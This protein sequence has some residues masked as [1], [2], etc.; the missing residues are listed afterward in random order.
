MGGKAMLKTVE[1]E[2]LTIARADANTLSVTDGKG[3]V[4]RITIPDV[5]QSNGIIHVVDKVLIPD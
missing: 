1:G 2:D 4:A 5:M 3:D